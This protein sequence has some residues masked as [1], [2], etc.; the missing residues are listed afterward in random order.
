MDEDEL[1]DRLRS[2]LDT[3]D[4]R[5]ALGI[6]DDAA[7][8]SNGS[9]V[10]VDAQVEGTHFLREWLPPALIAMRGVSTA[11][12]DLAAMGARASAVL[13]SWE[14]PA[15]E[16]DATIRAMIDGLADASRRYAVPVVGGNVSRGPGIAQHTTVIGE[17]LGEPVRR[18]GARSG[19]VVYVTGPI[20]AAALG[21]ACLRGGHAG[22]FA[23]RW[24]RPLARLDLAATIAERASAAI[25]VSDGLVSE[26]FH[27]AAA[28]GVGF[29]VELARVPRDDAFDDHAHA[30]GLDPEA[31]I[32]EGGEDYELLFTSSSAIDPALA[33][34]I[35]KVTA[36]RTMV[37]RRA[38]GSRWAGRGGFRHR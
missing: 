28:S 19:D 13:V 30:D 5:V 18:S 22:A 23:E 36:T 32:A 10:S 33:T 21:L 6:G 4:D 11:L 35:G 15:A 16:P 25:D 12:S 7:V 8:L 9:V 38:D 26:L 34:A 3:S 1:I 14:L 37:V 29:E 31:L 2:A 27:L 24:Q 17:A 20:G